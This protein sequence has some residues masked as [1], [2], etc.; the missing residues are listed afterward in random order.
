MRDG[1]VWVVA[2][3]ALITEG[4]YYLAADP[5][6]GQC[7]VSAVRG[8]GLRLQHLVHRPIGQS[9]LPPARI[10]PAHTVRDHEG[11]P[12]EVDDVVF[13]C[14]IAE[15]IEEL[16]A[17]HVRGGAQFR[18]ARRIE[19]QQIAILATVFNDKPRCYAVALGPD[20]SPRIAW[21]GR[22]RIARPALELGYRH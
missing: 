8:F 16:A 14:G 12:T 19:F 17:N 9:M 2:P 21:A 13:R 20:N 18:K 4:S 10:A 22:R 7:A 15:R 3:C 11:F 1:V 5:A 6:A